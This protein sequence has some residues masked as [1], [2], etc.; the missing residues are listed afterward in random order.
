MYRAQHAVSTINYVVTGAEQ[1]EGTRSIRA[2]G[3][4]LPEALVTNESTLLVADKTTNLD[5]LEDAR[6]YASVDF[7]RRYEPG[8]DRLL[9]AEEL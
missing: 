3:F 5:S 9:Q 6:G 1:Q 4:A 8:K 7:R 2:L